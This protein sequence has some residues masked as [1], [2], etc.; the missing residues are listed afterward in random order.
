MRSW[1]ASGS[2]S[3]GA[4]IRLTV[5]ASLLALPA[6]TQACGSGEGSGYTPPTFDAGAGGVLPPGGGG[7]TVD[8]GAWSD[9]APAGGADSGADAGLL[10]PPFLGGNVEPGGVV[11]RVWAPDATSANV[12]VDSTP[13]DVPMNAIGGGVY[14]AHV[15]GAKAGSTY[16][17]VFAGP[18]GTVTRFDPYCRELAGAACRVVDPNA[19]AW[20]T[21]SFARPKRAGA[22]VYEFHVGSYAVPT[23]AATGT[24]ASTR[25]ALPQIADLGVNVIEVMPVQSFGGSAGGWGYNPQLFQA[26]MPGLGTSDDF[27][28]LVDAAHALGIAVWVDAVIN[29]TDGWTQAPLYCFDGECPNQTAGIYFFPQGTYAT[30]PWGPRPDYAAPEVATM[31]AA[32]VDTWM[33][34]LRADGFRWDSVSNVRALDGQ[35]T[36]PGATDLLRRINDRVHALDGLSIAEDLKGYGAITQSTASGGFGFDAQWDGF[37]YTMTNVIVPPSDAGRDLGQVVGALEGSSGGDPFGRLIYLEDHDT[38]GN[39]GSRIP[40]A[41]DSANP[42]SFAA[43]KRSML[44]A[45]VMLTTPGVPMLFMG[46]EWLATAPFL[47]PPTPLAGPTAVGELVRAFYRDMVRLRRNLDGLAGGLSDP[48][49]EI[50]HRNDTAKVLGYRRYGASGEDVLVVANF[51]STSFTA[52]NVGVPDANPWRVRVNSDLPA[53]GSDFT[54]TQSGS[55]SP[56]PIATD[57]KPYALPLVLGPYSAIV[58]TR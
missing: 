29:H 26:P 11:F 7:P 34:E 58:L 18:G 53:Y 13:N 54:G 19:Y 17:Y 56:K 57:G 28:A 8:G 30:T 3:E 25:A 41:I 10:T 42:T 15:P 14:E 55:V 20:T 22:V 4:G 2:S 12:R 38:V 39:G 52:Y 46:E 27:R 1:S 32:S 40:A 6:W 5:L 16:L 43:R 9:A 35:G 23:G 47:S 21:P 37:G 48:G 45:L 51:S 44:G 49:V 33:T 50:V 31:L 36:V 24:F